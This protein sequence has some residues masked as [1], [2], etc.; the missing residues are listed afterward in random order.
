MTCRRRIRKGRELLEKPG[1]GFFFTLLPLPKVW[2]RKPGQRVRGREGGLIESN[3]TDG[4]GVS[5]C[6][7]MIHTLKSLG[8][9]F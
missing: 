3:L 7:W 2:R 4:V 5:G 1:G 8:Y 6:N 9:F